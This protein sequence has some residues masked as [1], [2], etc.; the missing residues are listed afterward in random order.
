MLLKS[1]PKHSGSTAWTLKWGT[2]PWWYKYDTEEA[3]HHERQGGGNKKSGTKDTLQEHVPSDPHFP[4][5]KSLFLM[6]SLGFLSLLCLLE[7]GH[8]NH[9]HRGIVSAGVFWGPTVFS[10]TLNFCWLFLKNKERL[11]RLDT[12]CH[13]LTLEETHLTYFL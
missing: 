7:L 4:P 6:S 2:M 8:W 9:F 1:L 3:M 13:P 11:A 12:T 5:P 10:V